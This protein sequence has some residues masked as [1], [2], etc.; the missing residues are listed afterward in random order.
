M[1]KNL[2]ASS[3][4]ERIFGEVRREREESAGKTP[5]F[6][7][8]INF[9]SPFPSIPTQTLPPPKKS[10]KIAVFRQFGGR[11]RAG[12]APTP[13][14]CVYFCNLNSY[15]GI[16]ARFGSLSAAFSRDFRAARGRSRRDLPVWVGG[17]SEGQVKLS[18]G[19]ANSL[20]SLLFPF[21]F[22]F[23]SLFPPLCFN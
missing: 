17:Q 20:F 5:N 18:L 9:P 23:S 1:G 8:Y 6:H 16:F 14:I 2:G 12:F 22:P 21:Y 7:F 19:C 10:A 11:S 13:V 3:G 4:S 15:N